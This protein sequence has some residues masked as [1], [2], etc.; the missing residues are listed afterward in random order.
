[1]RI[2]TRIT[3]WYGVLLLASLL[4]M[5]GG[6]YFELIV[7]RRAAKAQGL[8]KERMEDEV[9]EVV[10][11]YCIPS[12][13]ITILGGWWVMRRSLAP[14]DALTQ[15]AERIQLNNLREPLPDSGNGDEID[16]LAAVLNG[17]TQRLD[18]SF[19]QM[20]EFALH[21]SHEMKTPLAILHG[22]V[23][24]CLQDP[25]ATR[26]QRETY[27][28]LLDEIQRLIK[29]VSALAFL[30][31]ADAGQAVIQRESVDLEEMVRD[32]VADAEM[33]GRA[34]HL[35]VVLTHSEPISILGDRHRLRQLLLNL[36]ENAIKYNQTHGSMEF[37]LGN[38]GGRVE[39]TV[40]NTG[41]GIPPDRLLRVF[42]RFF[43]G[44]P[45]HSEEVDGC[46]L[47]LTIARSIV[48]SHGGTITIASAPESLTVVTV[49]L[50]HL[51][52]GAAR[53]PA[54]CASLTPPSEARR[55]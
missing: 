3:L 46:G 41:P 28:S 44:D 35:R 47:G 19:L 38:V 42:E 43:R 25:A 24:L 55:R 34:T 12:I 6:M 27:S 7:E 51:A 14:L 11:V 1:M 49:R 4:V 45:A 50:P 5:G 40:S 2:R 8:P 37:W 13:L 39:L 21:A 32:A 10:L 33:L 48:E 54:L 30:A 20:H 18:K 23:E 9:V 16:R 26:S 53:T 22:E 31:K 15:R 36:T 17:M 29:I 52:P